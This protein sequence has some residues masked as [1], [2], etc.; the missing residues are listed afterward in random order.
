MDC[1]LY[2]SDVET[3]TF[4]EI[5]DCTDPLE[6]S[7]NGFYCIEALDTSTCLTYNDT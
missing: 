2:D 1:T 4:A 3:C 7:P 6:P 5:T